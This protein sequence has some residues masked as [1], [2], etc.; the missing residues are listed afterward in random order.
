MATPLLFPDLA[1][2]AA[3]PACSPMCWETFQAARW[4]SL[5]FAS[6]SWGYLGT[7][8]SG[9]RGTSSLLLSAKA[10]PRGIESVALLF[11]ASLGLCFRH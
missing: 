1:A 9:Q 7:P 8:F 2:Y 3:P 4:W 6:W 11:L 10:L 5:L